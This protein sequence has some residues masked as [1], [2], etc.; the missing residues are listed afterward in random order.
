MFCFVS[1]SYRFI[2]FEYMRY[3]LCTLW[4]IYAY[5]SCYVL[6]SSSS[7]FDERNCVLFSIGM[8]SI[9]WKK[10]YNLHVFLCSLVIW[11]SFCCV[12]QCA[13]LYLTTVVFFQN[14]KDNVQSLF[15]FHQN[16]QYTH[17]YFKRKQLKLPGVPQGS[18]LIYNKRPLRNWP[19]ANPKEI[20]SMIQIASWVFMHHYIHVPK[21]IS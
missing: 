14:L 17:W 8:V 12:L 4:M 19:Y 3:P 20:G 1:Y 16:F 6:F 15:Q 13:N 7:F 10:E 5:L 21:S 2:S 9:M 11:H 18:I